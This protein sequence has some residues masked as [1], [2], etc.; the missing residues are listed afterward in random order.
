IEKQLPIDLLSLIDKAV[1]LYNKKLT[2]T[3][4]VEQIIHFMLNRLLSWYKKQG[5]SIDTINAVMAV[6]K[7]TG[8]LIHFDAR[9]RAV[10]Y[11]RQIPHAENLTK[12]IFNIIAKHKDLINGEVNF[13]LLKQPEEVILINSITQLHKKLILFFEKGKYQEALWEL[14]NLR[15]IINT[16]FSKIIIM[17]ENKELCINRLNIINKVRQLFLII[18]DF[19]LLQC[20]KEKSNVD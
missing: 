9:L 5:Y 8:K 20:S 11:L 1:F 2:N 18:A 16:F 14:I 4:V 12:R 7:P 17:T 15:E 6:Y 10:H 13:T 19:S 3:I